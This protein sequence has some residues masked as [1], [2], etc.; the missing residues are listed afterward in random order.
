MP[1]ALYPDRLGHV[2]EGHCGKR[3]VASFGTGLPSASYCSGAKMN[4]RD[5]RFFGFIAGCLVAVGPDITPTANDGCSAN[6]RDPGSGRSAEGR[7]DHLRPRPH[8]YR[9]S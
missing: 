6:Q 5:L 3:S 4:Q 2:C 7:N 1:L 8:S 9:G